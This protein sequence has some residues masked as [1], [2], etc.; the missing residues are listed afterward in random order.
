MQ[1]KLTDRRFFYIN[2]RRIQN[3]VSKSIHKPIG[4]DPELERSSGELE[5]ILRWEDDG[6]LIVGVNVFPDDLPPISPRPTKR[7]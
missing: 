3:K 4:P 7:A 5:N 6:G 1:N 2:T